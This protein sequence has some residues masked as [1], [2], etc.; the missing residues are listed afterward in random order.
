MNE[1]PDAGRTPAEIQTHDIS[2]DMLTLE[3]MPA[4]CQQNYVHRTQAPTEC[5]IIRVR[6]EPVAG[7]ARHDPLMPSTSSPV[8]SPSLTVGEILHPGNK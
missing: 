6:I 1:D 2:G 8:L 7:G 4:G 3:N 5:T